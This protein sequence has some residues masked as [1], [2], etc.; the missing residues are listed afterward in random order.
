M[1]KIV[2]TDTKYLETTNGKD[3]PNQ[4]LYQVRYNTD[5]QRFHLLVKTRLSIQCQYATNLKQV[6]EFLRQGK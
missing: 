5:L 3:Y 2:R 1:I 6:K 4:V